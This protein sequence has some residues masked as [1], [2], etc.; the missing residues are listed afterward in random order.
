MERIFELCNGDRL[1]CTEQAAV[2]RF[3]GPR[4]LLVHPVMAVRHV[5]ESRREKQKL[6]GRT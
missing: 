5:I 6:E 2:F 4:M 1:T 3:S